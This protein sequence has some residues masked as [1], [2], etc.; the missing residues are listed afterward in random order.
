MFE[1]V[2]LHRVKAEI[3]CDKMF[4]IIMY[5]INVGTKRSKKKPSY[6]HLSD[7]C[8]IIISLSILIQ[9]EKGKNS[10]NIGRQ[11]LYTPNLTS[12]D[13]PNGEKL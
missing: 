3:R 8:R 2:F 11:L 6:V 13:A 7:D 9:G 5:F 4:W 12:L 10:T 1:L